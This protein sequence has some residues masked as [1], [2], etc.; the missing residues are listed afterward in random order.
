MRYLKLRLEIMLEKVHESEFE[1]FSVKAQFL[2]L[3]QNINKF[4]I[5]YTIITAQ[6]IIL[7]QSN[8][9]FLT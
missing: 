5:T 1:K 9:V 3:N 4:L 8:R 2:I 7:D 6:M